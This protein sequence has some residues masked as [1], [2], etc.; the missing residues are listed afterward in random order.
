MTDTHGPHEQPSA[1]AVRASALA[2]LASGNSLE[3]VAHVFGVPV[4]TLQSWASQPASTLPAAEPSAAE[5]V[6]QWLSFPTPTSYALGPMGKCATIALGLLLS[7]CPV[8]AWPF[9]FEDG[10]RTSTY[11]IFF[12]LAAACVGLATAGILY[13]RRARFEMRPHAIAKY[14]LSAA[15][16]LPYSQIVGLTTTRNGKSASYAI[17]LQTSPGTPAMTINPEDAHLRDRNLSTWLN[18]IP[19][20]S[21]DP[22][23][24]RDDDTGSSGASRVLSWLV[25]VLMV[26][27]L[28]LFIRMPIAT[29]RAVLAGY[30]PLQQLSMTE[31]TLTR[32]DNCYRPRRGSSYVVVGIRTS[33]GERSQSLDCSIDSRV[34]ARP[35]PHHIVIYRDE[36]HFSD[37]AVRQVELDGQVLQDYA[38][39]L[40]RS[41]H[42]DP[43]MLTWQLM[44]LGM[45]G[46][47]GYGFFESRRDD[48]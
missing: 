16:I 32:V 25:N 17:V 40:A 15:T 3:S 46:L 4:D 44:M 2:L 38:A 23:R 11:F 8:L 12:L 5:P 19:L 39:F 6:R 21:G 43:A 10:T 26:S 22:I 35:G 27:M 28:L 13:A 36:R 14:G 45:L 41:R 20:Q 7:S 42:F 9:V 48:D 31:G 34:L 29:A 47:L 37:S 30:P 33:A 1:E 24:R 18:S